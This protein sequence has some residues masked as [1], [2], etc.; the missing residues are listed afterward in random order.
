MFSIELSFGGYRSENEINSSVNDRKRAIELAQSQE[1]ILALKIAQLM[2]TFKA[3]DR[4]TIVGC[5]EL[6]WLKQSQRE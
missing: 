4:P 5:F 6:Y 1:K 3:K 2:S